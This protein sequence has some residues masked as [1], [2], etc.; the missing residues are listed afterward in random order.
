MSNN[1]PIKRVVIHCS[2]SP[3]RG[4]GAETIHEWHLARGWAGIGYHYVINELG[5]L[6]FGRP[7]YWIG[8]HVAEFNSN[9]I[10]I[11]LL[12]VDKFTDAQW[13]TLRKLVIDLR[14]RHGKVD[15]CGHTDLDSKKSCPNFNVKKWLK[16]QGL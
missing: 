15:V 4:D 14:I 2:D 1:Y 8:S 7:E 10:G 16:E 13:S 11:C 6:E 5:E 12:G 3:H 9:S